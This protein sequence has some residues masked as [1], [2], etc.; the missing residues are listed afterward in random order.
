MGLTWDEVEMTALDRIG[1]REWRH[2]APCG[3]KSKKKIKIR[4]TPI[5][6][7]LRTQSDPKQTIQAIRGQYPKIE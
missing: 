2:H 7:H 3:A 6:R 4:K 5:T 1:D